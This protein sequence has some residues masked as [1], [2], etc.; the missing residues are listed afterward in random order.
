MWKCRLP[1]CVSS[2]EWMCVLSARQVHG[3]SSHS[4]YALYTGGRKTTVGPHPRGS[5]TGVPH[6]HGPHFHKPHT[7]GSQSCELYSH[8]PHPCGPHSNF[9]TCFIGVILLTLIS[10]VTTNDRRTLQQNQLW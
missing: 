2:V 7:R 4:G 9:V 1:G 3:P 10:S 6:S 8:G 5:Q